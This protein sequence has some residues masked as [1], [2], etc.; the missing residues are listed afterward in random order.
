MSPPEGKRQT[1]AMVQVIRGA[2]LLVHSFAHLTNAVFIKDPKWATHGA[3]GSTWRDKE[4]APA[5]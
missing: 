1:T 4:A 5:W 3:R 2:V